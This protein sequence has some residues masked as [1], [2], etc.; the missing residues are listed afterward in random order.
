MKQSFGQKGAG[1]RFLALALALIMLCSVLVPAYAA[2]VDEQGVAE[3]NEPAAT[4]SITYIFHVGETVQEVKVASGE[5]LT[6][7]TDPNAPEGEVFKGWFVDN[8][9]NKP[10]TFG[11][12]VS[13]HADEAV[14]LYAHF[15]TAVAASTEQQDEQQPAA[16]G[17]SE[18]PKQ[19]ET[20]APTDGGEE[21]KDEQGSTENNE[22]QTGENQ[23]ENNGENTG[24][25]TTPSDPTTPTD[26]VTPV[27]PI[28]PAEAQPA[29]ALPAE[30]NPEGEQIIYTTDAQTVEELYDRLMAAASLEEMNSL[31]ENLT[32][33]QNE[34]LNQF[35]EIQEAALEAKMNEFGAYDVI[36]LAAREVSIVRPA[37]SVSVNPRSR[38]LDW[39]S[40]ANTDKIAGFTVSKST[41]S[42]YEYTIAIDSSV[43]PGNYTLKVSYGN[44]GGYGVQAWSSSDTVT[45]KVTSTENAEAAVY[46]LMS[47]SAD[48][49]TNDTSVWCPN[50]SRLLTATVNTT[51]ADWVG[52]YRDEIQSD[53]STERKYFTNKNIFNPANYILT[54]PNVL[55]KQTDGSWLL[56]R[57]ASAWTLIFNTYQK[58]L[59]KQGITI[60]EHKD[61][62]AIYLIPYK[63][64]RDNGGNYPTHIDCEVSIVLDDVFT[65]KFWV[66]T[67][68]GSVNLS[69]SRTLKSTELVQNSTLPT[70]EFPETWYYRV[71]GKTYRIDGWYREDDTCTSNKLSYKKEDNSWPYTPTTD[72][73]EKGTIN[74]YAH[75]V[76][77]TADLVITKTVTGRL[78]SDAKSFEFSYSYVD[79]NKE[80]QEG[81]FYLK[82]G[83]STSNLKE[84]PFES[85]PVGTV[86]T[87]TETSYTSE[88]YTTYYTV[89]SEDEKS[90][91]SCEIT[92]AAMDGEDNPNVV[93]FRNDK[94]PVPDTGLTLDSWPYLLALCFVTLGAVVTLARGRRRD[95]D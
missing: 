44:N 71:D 59:A 19:P 63:I 66:I 43:L 11:T 79:S 69:E 38:Y 42:Y 16:P 13:T 81:T 1:G 72:D 86:V 25:T 64:S 50:D 47:P 84:N 9:L 8:D 67:P 68:D 17:T 95:V 15:E 35:D 29:E 14:H 24:D 49:K 31:L 77:I 92:L 82:D 76:P 54:M 56:D 85:L 78:G 32:E 4:G 6:K 18:E 70:T 48:P 80:T 89:G 34:L 74:F 58:E 20:N 36:T 94:N 12:T 46:F 75:Y 57:N 45:V 5:A 22:N 87:I 40:V 53:G 33:A 2:V 60:T 26:P 65:V 7:P 90:G 27:E 41:T 28:V 83:E 37:S 39:V 73:L 51:G 88:G 55:T 91:N 21:N 23:T 52:G 10:F 93:T 3:Q 61:V 62:K 30:E